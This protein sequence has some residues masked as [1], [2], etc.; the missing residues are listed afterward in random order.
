MIHKLS[1]SVLVLFVQ[2]IFANSLLR[3][4]QGVWTPMG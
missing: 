1:E 3:A 2:V 4:P